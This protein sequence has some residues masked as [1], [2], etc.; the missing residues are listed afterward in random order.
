MV[1]YLSEQRASRILN[2]IRV[3]D[4]VFH[5]FIVGQCVEAVILG[6]LCIVGMLILRLPYAAMVGTLIGCTALIPVAGAY[7][8]GAVGAFMI[9][10]VSPAQAVVFLIFLVCL[11]QFEGNLI[12]PRAVGSSIGLPAIWVL[13]AVT[14]GGGV[15]GI[16][17]MLI[18]VPLA[19]AFYQIIYDDV[20]SRRKD[21][22]AQ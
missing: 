5:R 1:T 4:R 11:Q 3:F 8:G 13:A 14:V 6:G 2:V 21:S 19:A 16:F 18:A 10:T 17:G 20:K 7:I 22:P 15:G 12:Y 9:F